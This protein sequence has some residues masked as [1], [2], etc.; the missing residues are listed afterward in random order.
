MARSDFQTTHEPECCALTQKAAE[1]LP[2]VIR[3]LTAGDVPGPRN[4]GFDKT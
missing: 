3:V 2:G 4:A 1:N